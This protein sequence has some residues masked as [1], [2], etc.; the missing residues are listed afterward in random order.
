MK[1]PVKN[2]LHPLNYFAPPNLKMGAFVLKIV[3]VF[4]KETILSVKAR[5]F[6]LILIAS[7]AVR[8][9]VEVLLFVLG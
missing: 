2:K 9:V 3:S 5:E 7:T 8:S 6:V 4:N 1:R